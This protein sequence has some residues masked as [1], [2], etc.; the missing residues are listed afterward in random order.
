MSV[1]EDDFEVIRT[2][3]EGC[4][5]KVILV[6]KMTGKD[7]SKEYAMKQINKGR[8]V[9]NPILKAGVM[10]ERDIM[11]QV[12]GVSFF[13]QLYYTFQTPSFL[14]YL[15]DPVDGCELFEFM[16]KMGVFSPEVAKFY[17][18]Q[19]A[20]ILG[21][22]HDRG[23]VFRDL[24]PENMMVRVDTGYLQLVDFGHATSGITDYNHKM[25]TFCGTR[26]YKSPEMVNFTEGYTWSCDWWAL[27]IMMY[28][29][30]YGTVPYD[31]PDENV[32]DKMI[33]EGK[34]ELPKTST[35]IKFDEKSWE[36]V[37]EFLHPDFNSRLG[38]GHDDFL[39]IR[40]HP[41][42]SNY[43]WAALEA[44]TLPTPLGDLSQTLVASVEPAVGFLGP[45]KSVS[46]N[47]DGFEYTHPSLT[48][49][50]GIDD[51]CNFQSTMLY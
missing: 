46:Y 4:F 50:I 1:G 34:I 24:K 30:L 15:M 40:Y 11:L 27:G 18:C 14:Y 16:N 23:I 25:Y 28:D 45:C 6:R 33:L 35:K 48:E 7:K 51:I 2:L 49:D 43:D 38:A 19:I 37:Q 3:G 8:V 42:Y 22:L 29:M 21:Y 26:V 47:F 44:Q 36:V 10:D 20:M 17:V 41:Y 39:E 32:L 31:H 5:G 13:P 12:A 9:H